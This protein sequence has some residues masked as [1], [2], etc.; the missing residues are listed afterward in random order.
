MDFFYGPWH[1]QCSR[2]VSTGYSASVLFP[3]KHFSFSVSETS[4]FPLYSV[5]LAWSDFWIEPNSKS[6]SKEESVNRWTSD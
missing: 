2:Q 4:N 1:C 6:N 3:G 5:D